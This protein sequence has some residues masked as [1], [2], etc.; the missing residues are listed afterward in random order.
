M[1]PLCG[2]AVESL[3]I[4]PGSYRPGCGPTPEAA[5][6]RAT[7]SYACEKCCRKF[8]ITEKDT[9]KQKKI[10]QRVRQKEEREE[11]RIRALD[12]G[13]EKFPFPVI[14]FSVDRYTEIREEAKRE[15]E[16]EARLRIFI[17][18]LIW[19]LLWRR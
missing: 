15:V 18:G 17:M 8:L 16:T 19:F 5:H 1:C 12:T 7:A 9:E 3:Q 2:K 10:A 4:V 11:R 13:T 6:R 14:P